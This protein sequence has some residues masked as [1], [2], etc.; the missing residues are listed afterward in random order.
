MGGSITSFIVDESTVMRATC[1]FG[2]CLELS[3]V[4]QCFYQARR[5][6]VRYV[7]LLMGDGLRRGTGRFNV[8]AGRCLGVMSR[9]VNGKS[10]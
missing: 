5:V 6:C 9:F 8:S 2:S 7:R 3:I 10:R 4:T 1:S